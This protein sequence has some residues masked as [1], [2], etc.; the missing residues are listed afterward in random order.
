MEKAPALVLEHQGRTGKFGIGFPPLFTLNAVASVMILGRNHNF[1]FWQERHSPA[2][3]GKNAR[4]RC[5]A[6]RSDWYFILKNSFVSLPAAK[7]VPFHGWQ[8]V[9]I[10]PSFLR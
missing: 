2:T 8:S 10:I 4:K 5:R 1:T 9:R 7:G 3:P 6:L